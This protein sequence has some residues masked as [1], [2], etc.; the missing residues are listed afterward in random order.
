M[1]KAEGRNYRAN[2]MTTAYS[3]NEMVTAYSV[4]EMVLANSAIDVNSLQC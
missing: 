4:N 1:I 2:E 3:A